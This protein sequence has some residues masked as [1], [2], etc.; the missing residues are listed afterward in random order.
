MEK[1]QVALMIGT[2]EEENII[3]SETIYQLIVEGLQLA[4]ETNYFLL[5]AERG[6]QSEI[7]QWGI[8]RR[9]AA[10]T[11][12]FISEVFDYHHCSA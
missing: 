11:E 1:S 9:Q 2:K 6:S 10:Q 12:K 4:A 3:K 5:Y 8:P 7:L